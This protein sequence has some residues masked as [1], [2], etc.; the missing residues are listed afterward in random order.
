MCKAASVA[1]AANGVAQDSLKLKA[2][3]A[4][5]SKAIQMACGP[6]ESS[7]RGVGDM[8]NVSCVSE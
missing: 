5:A 7:V 2:T 3:L 6:D 8:R 4:S 1:N